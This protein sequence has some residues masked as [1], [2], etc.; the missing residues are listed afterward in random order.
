MQITCIAGGASVLSEFSEIDIACT[1]QT[2]V[3]TAADQARSPAPTPL[4][5][6][7]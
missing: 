7:G 4:D 1:D 6:A 3:G 2:V 5:N